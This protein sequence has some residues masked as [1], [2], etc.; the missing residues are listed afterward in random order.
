MTPGTLYYVS[1]WALCDNTVTYTS[2]LPITS[3][4]YA[5]TSSFT[6]PLAYPTTPMNLVP[7]L[8]ATNVPVQPNFAW[9]AVTG[10]TA[11]TLDIT[12][13]TDVNFASPIY[14]NAAIPNVV[15]QPTVTWNYTGAALANNTSYIWR[16]KATGSTSAWV[17]GNFTTIPAVVP[18]VTVTNP[19]AIT[20][21]Q[22]A[23]N[24][25]PT[26]I[27]SQQPAVTVTVGSPVTPVITFP[28]LTVTQLP[29][30]TPPTP[31]Y[32]WI[33]VGVGALLTLAVIILIIRTRRVV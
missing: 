24:P 22:A 13:A 16:V 27:L 1:V 3:F 9:A 17:L 10:A 15:G 5:G 32:I 21:T 2:P 23:A 7:A 29:A 20:L 19:P 11:Y 12:T 6:T 8:G 28:G 30:E 18:P 4:M 31:A 25:V 33:I 26:I 14:H